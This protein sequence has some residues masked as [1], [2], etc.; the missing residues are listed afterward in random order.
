MCSCQLVIFS[1]VNM[2]SWCHLSH[3][4]LIRHVIRQFCHASSCTWQWHAVRIDFA[5][6]PG[7]LVNSWKKGVGSQVASNKKD[8]KKRKR[9]QREKRRKKCCCFLNKRLVRVVVLFVP[10]RL[11]DTPHVQ[12]GTM[13]C[14]HPTFAKHKRRNVEKDITTRRHV[15]PTKKRHVTF[16]ISE[17]SKLIKGWE[18]DTNRHGHHQQENNGKHENTRTQRTQRTQTKTKKSQKGKEKQKN[19]QFKIQTS[20]ISFWI[21][22]FQNFHGFSLWKS[23]GSRAGSKER[24]LCDFARPPEHSLTCLTSSD[25]TCDTCEL[26]IG[27]QMH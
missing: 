20:N 14:H 2:M 10:I 21:R 4:C 3:F 27:K 13:E 19:K 9:N 6:P 5:D 15:C 25:S 17:W 26:N 8:V 12:P 11:T 1:V 16:S 7:Q 18:M 24:R 23:P 22:T